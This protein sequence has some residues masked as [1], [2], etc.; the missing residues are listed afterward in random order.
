M[1]QEEQLK[2]HDARIRKLE[3]FI[4]VNLSKLLDVTGNHSTRLEVLET[5]DDETMKFIHQTC[6]IKDKEI[7]KVREEAIEISCEHADK[8]HKQTWGLIVL[9]VSAFLTFAG[10][11]SSQ[12]SQ[13][14]LDIQKHDVEIKNTKEL[15]EK[16]DAKMDKIYAHI[17][18]DKE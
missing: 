10:Y 4:L 18:S 13:R 7:Q 17:R 3:D 6:A 14:A 12:N 16:M 1:S 11:I 15:L 5:H 8:N 9:V 2:D